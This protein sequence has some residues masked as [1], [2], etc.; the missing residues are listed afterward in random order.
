MMLTED[1][2]RKFL[3]PVTFGRDTGSPDRCIAS[4]CIAWRWRR[5]YADDARE[6]HIQHATGYC[7]LAGKP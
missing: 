1:E 3:C 4:K 7:G 6:A 2:A 5:R